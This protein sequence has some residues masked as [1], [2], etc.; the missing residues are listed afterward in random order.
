MGGLSTPERSSR[1]MRLT[2]NGEGP[3]DEGNTTQQGGGG[4]QE[5]FGKTRGIVTGTKLP[6]KYWNGKGE[7][8]RLE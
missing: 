4:W 5:L 2:Q 7:K 1:G 6:N 8:E 3:R